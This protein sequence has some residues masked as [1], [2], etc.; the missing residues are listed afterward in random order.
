MPMT[1]RPTLAALLLAA[2]LATLEYL[3]EQIAAYDRGLAACESPA[4]AFV[5]A[6]RAVFVLVHCAETRKEVVDSRAA[7]AALWF[8]NAAPYT[9]RVAR[10]NWFNIVRGHASQSAAGREVIR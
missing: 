8:M 3:R 7:E 2:P 5:N 6:Q 4:G 10:D 1:L 9:F